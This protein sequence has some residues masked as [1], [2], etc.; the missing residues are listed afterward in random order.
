MIPDVDVDEVLTAEIRKDLVIRSGVAYSDEHVRQCSVEC[1][2]V[3]FSK[4]PDLDFPDQFTLILLSSD[5]QD[6]RRW[7]VQMTG[8]MTPVFYAMYSGLKRLDKLG[9]SKE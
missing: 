5:E 7:Q 2:D 3:Y 6:N 9:E 4:Q 8:E 1:C